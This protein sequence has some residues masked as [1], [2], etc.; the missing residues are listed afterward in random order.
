MGGLP[1]LPPLFLQ[2]N[3]GMRLVVP[4]APSTS[5]PCTGLF[6]SGVRGDYPPTPMVAAAACRRRRRGPLA[7]TPATAERKSLIRLAHPVVPSIGSMRLE[8]LP[9]LPAPL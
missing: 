8:N 1:P 2:A 5:I 6:R 3:G 7:L 4:G 9:L